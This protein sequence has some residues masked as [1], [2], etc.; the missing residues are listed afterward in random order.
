MSKASE[1]GIRNSMTQ[2]YG[3]Y[4]PTPF[5]TDTSQLVYNQRYPEGYRRRKLIHSGKKR[6]TLC[7]IKLQM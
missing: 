7:D 3:S 1:R 4:K 6:T 5:Y 2:N